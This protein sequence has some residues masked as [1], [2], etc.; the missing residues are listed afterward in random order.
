MDETITEWNWYAS[1]TFWM[2]YSSKANAL[3][4]QK[5]FFVFAFVCTDRWTSTNIKSTTN[6]IMFEHS[7]LWILSFSHFQNY[8]ILEPFYLNRIV[9]N[10]F[11]FHLNLP[12]HLMDWTGN[13]STAFEN[14]YY[15]MIIKYLHKRILHN[16][17]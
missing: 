16:V 10:C 6:S 1:G 12:K 14:Y 13:N 11:N 8:F 5:A 15:Y 3:L 9:S 17:N 7:E 4:K 2:K